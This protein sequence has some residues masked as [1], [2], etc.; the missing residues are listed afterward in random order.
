[1]MQ[2]R[3]PNFNDRLEAI[4]ERSMPNAQWVPD[5]SAYSANSMLPARLRTL[6]AMTNK[7][8]RTENPLPHVIASEVAAPEL[9]SSQGAERYFQA[10]YR[11]V[12]PS[13]LGLQKRGDAASP[14]I[15]KVDKEERRW[16]RIFVRL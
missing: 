2:N 3:L 8:V 7:E 14:C 13:P 11:G 16:R 4:E 15:S 9:V 1:M 6:V 12:E 10:P 5:R